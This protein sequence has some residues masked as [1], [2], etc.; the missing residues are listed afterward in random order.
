[1][2]TGSA[3]FLMALLLAGGMTL[4][5]KVYLPGPGRNPENGET[6]RLQS[7][8]DFPGQ[9]ELMT[10]PARFNGVL[11]ELRVSLIKRSLEDVLRELREYDPLLKLTLRPGTVT[12]SIG[13]GKRQERVLLTG[14]SGSVTVFSMELPDP[15]PP[16]REW[17]DA[18]PLPRGAEAL[19]TV[20]LLNRGSAYGSFRNAAPGSLTALAGSLVQQGYIAVT[21]ESA[22]ERGRGELFLDAKRRRIL[23][24]S[25]AEDGTG[26]LLLNRIKK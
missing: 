1:M 8:R 5:A 11:T 19:E 10:E 13:R 15:L 17:P 16:C 3:K 4:S 14:N 9:L 12:F 7:F 21:A 23:A 18:L 2:K 22:S 6:R 26:T 24:V 20:E 25:I